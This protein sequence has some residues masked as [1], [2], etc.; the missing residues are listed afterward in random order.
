MKYFL[1]FLSLVF[2]VSCQSFDT[3]TN[4]ETAFEPKAMSADDD[5]DDHIDEALSLMY[6]KIGKY[7]LLTK[8]KTAVANFIMG[9]NIYQVKFDLDGSWRESEV[10]IAYEFT[11]PE[12]LQDYIKSDE[13]KGWILAE[14]KLKQAPND[15]RY[16]FVFKK[17]EE[18]LT[19]W[20]DREGNVIK[21]KTDTQQLVK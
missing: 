16:K 11:L 4:L 15:I 19:I 18:L 2:M 5:L 9:G 8:Q 12:K 14:K 10:E 1:T 21:D 6:P 20:L 7:K 3:D 17:G 13:F